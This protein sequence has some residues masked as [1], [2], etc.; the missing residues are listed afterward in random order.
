MSEYII[1]YLGGDE[2]SSPEEGKQHMSKYMQWLAS[3]GD[4]AISPA[5]PLKNTNTVSSD[6]SVMAGGISTMS[7]YTIIEAGSM[8]EAL[9]ISKSCPFLEMGGSLEVSELMRMP[10]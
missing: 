7:G 10:S 1:V 5:N 8:A 3:L 4:A 2:P 9:E 6:G